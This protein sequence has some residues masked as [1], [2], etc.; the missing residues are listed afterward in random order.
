MMYMQLTCYCNC[1]VVTRIIASLVQV[2]P[3]AEACEALIHHYQYSHIFSYDQEW[4]AFQLWLTTMMGMK[5]YPVQ[6]SAPA[7]DSN[8]CN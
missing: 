6:S 4:P 2:L 5:C 7:D 8:V 1:F 3:T